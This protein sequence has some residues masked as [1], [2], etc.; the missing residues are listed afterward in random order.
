MKAVILCGGLGSRLGEETELKPKPM[1]AVGGEPILCHIMKIYEKFGIREFILAL[2]YKSEYIKDYFLKYYRLNSDLE[3]DLSTGDVSFLRK[4]K[5]NWKIQLIDTGIDT[6]TGG[7]LKRLKPYLK[8]EEEFMLTYGDG[9][10][11][12]NIDELL[13]FH[14]EHKKIATVT[15]VK[16]TARFGGLHFDGDLITTFTEKPQEGEGWINGGFFVF[17]SKVFDYLGGDGTVLEREPLENLSRDQQL[18]AYRHDGFWQ[19]MDTIREKQLLEE[20]YS[21]GNP[22]WV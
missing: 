6:M 19:C 16:P 7:R 17:G 14:K 13:K 15:A 2:G 4:V 5:K 12:V 11:N 8:G 22:P 9:V 20:Y 1:V 3:V 21:S 18:V 10:A